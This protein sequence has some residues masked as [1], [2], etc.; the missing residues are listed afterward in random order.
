MVHSTILRQAVGYWCSPVKADEND[1]SKIVAMIIAAH[2]YAAVRCW[3]PG[4]P[5]SQVQAV[6]SGKEEGPDTHAQSMVLLGKHV[7]FVASVADNAPAGLD[8][9]G[10]FETTYLQPLK[11]I[12]GVPEKIA[13]IH[14][15]AKMALGV[16]SAASKSLKQSATNQ[17]IVFS[18]NWPKFIAS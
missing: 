9:T 7:T 13:D 12:D 8:A 10:D 14:P 5:A 17:S 18:R 15:Y 16:L 4:E 3:L 1:R 6:S 11:I 2:H